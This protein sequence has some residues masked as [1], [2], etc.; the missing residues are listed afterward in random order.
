M[1]AIAASSGPPGRRPAATTSCAAIRARS[2]ALNTSTSLYRPHSLRIDQPRLSHHQERRVAARPDPQ[3][4]QHAGAQRPCPARRRRRCTATGR[5][6]YREDEWLYIGSTLWNAAEKLV[7]PLPGCGEGDRGG[8]PRRHGQADCARHCLS[9]SRSHA[10]YHRHK[11]R[12]RHDRHGDRQPAAAASIC[13]ALSFPRLGSGTDRSWHASFCDQI[14]RLCST[15]CA[16]LFQRPCSAAARLFRN[17]TSGTSI[18]NDYA[19]AEQF[20]AIADQMWRETN[21]ETACCENLY[22]MAAQHGVFPRPAVARRRLRQADR[23]A[24]HASAGLLRDQTYDRHLRFGRHG[25]AG[26]VAAGRGHRSHPRPDA[27]RRR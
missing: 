5:N 22:K 26:A 21:P 27:G 3:H 14:R 1:S 24:A 15:S 2:P 6:P 25:P 12:R 11:S 7:C 19:A 13:P 8:S 18:T 10:I 23:R 4:P 9:R 20:Y 16:M 17:R